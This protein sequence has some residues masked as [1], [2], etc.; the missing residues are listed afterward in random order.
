MRSVLT[1]ALGCTFLVAAPAARSGD[2]E[3]GAY[4]HDGKA[5]L[6]GYRL[7]MLRYGQ[8][9]AGQAVMIFVTEPFR[10]GARV[11][12]DDPSNNPADVFDALKLN[13]VRDFQTGIYDYN[14][15]VS[16]FVRSDTFAPVKVSFTSAEWCGNVYEELLVDPGRIR[17]QLHSYFEGETTS[18]TLP[19]P[20]AG[21]L[22]DELYVRL[23]GLRGEFL[24]SGGKRTVAFLPS[25][26]YRR[27]AHQ[28]TRW[29]IASIERLAAAQQVRVPAGSFSAA[30]YVVRVA[31]GR[32]G[33]FLIET[34]YPHRI[35]RWSWTPPRGVVAEHWLGA[36]D[37]GE[38]TGSARLVYWTL[39]AN[40]DERYLKQLGL[41][42][43]VNRQ[44]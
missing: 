12:A 9:R 33:R 13:L 14:T 8:P 17:H 29:T 27:M 21:M 5:E 37:S 41:A 2:P 16:L 35:V 32:E 22:E 24:P 31:D 11:K 7:T 30:E 3:F 15:M 28:P 39:H 40:G 36:A 38:L 42:P 44:R 6:D 26:F 20:A 25:T 19:R 23:R 4:W 34:A 1:I 43:S 10:E 18:G